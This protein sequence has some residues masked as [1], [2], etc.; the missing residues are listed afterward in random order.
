MATLTVGDVA[1]QAGL[2][3]K[4]VRLYEQT[5]LIRTA[6]RTESGYRTYDEGDVE[7]LRFIRQARALGLSLGEIK[8]ILDLQQGGARPCGTVLQLLDTHV[9]EIDDTMAT[10]R[11]LRR[12][13]VRARDAARVTQDRGQDAVICQIIEAQ[14]AV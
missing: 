9:K 12:T 1:E 2:S 10:L 6:R 13:L 5:G 14:P 7:V 3:P 4:A 8:Q 11:A